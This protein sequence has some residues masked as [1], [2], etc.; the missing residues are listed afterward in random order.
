MPIAIGYLSQETNSFSPVNTKLRDFDLCFGE[1]AVARLKNTNTEFAGFLDILAE[2]KQQTVPLFAGW[3]IPGGPVAEQDFSEIC[4]LVRD[5]FRQAGRLDGVL[6]AFHGAMCAHGSD[7][8]EGSLLEIIREEIGQSVPLIL[9]LDLHANVTRKMVTLAQAV[10][11]YKTWPHSDMH[12]TG[13][14]AGKLLMYSLREKIQLSTAMQKIPMILPAEN[15]L[16]AAGP[17]FEVFKVGEDFRAEH[18]TVCEISVFGVQ[19]WMDVSEMGCAVATVA[20][21]GDLTALE[22]TRQ[23]AQRFWD[24]REAFQVT[25]LKPKEAI[26]AALSVVGG[27]VVLSES[28][29]SPTAGS[30]GDSADMLKA[31]LEYAPQVPSVLWVRDPGVVESTWQRLPGERVEITIGGCYD[32]VNRRPIRIGGTL[33]S[34]SKGDYVLKGKFNKGLATSMGRTVVIEIGPISVV[35]SEGAAVMVDPE[36]YR[37]Q[38]VHLESRKIVVVKS[39]GMFRME[40]GPIAAAIFMVDT[41]GISSANIREVPYRHVPRPI[42]PLDPVQFDVRL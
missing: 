9:T 2:E 42:Y 26:E 5:Q 23:M 8:C 18:P 14:R 25:L 22:C 40:Y 35:V 17:M 28:S 12:E 6:L 10:I 4:T 41:P 27:P 36:V 39:P 3:A 38:G 29:D 21:N 11:G 31:L 1:T 24:L 13:R 19:P 15:M 16:T 20:A 30:P 32:R 7:D 33:Q 37:S 34:K